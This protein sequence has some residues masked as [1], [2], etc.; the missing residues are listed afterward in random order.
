MK[1]LISLALI[2]AM[3]L[4]F[5]ACDKKENSSDTSTENSQSSQTSKSE[6]SSTSSEPVSTSGSGWTMETLAKTICI[7]GKAI[8]NPLTI[9]SLGKEYSLTYG[10]YN[11]P[12]IS[13]RKKKIVSIRFK[14]ES[15][16]EID[17]VMT[18]WQSEEDSS[19]LSIN[20]IKVGSTRAEAEAAFGKPTSEVELTEN[21]SWS[22]YESG[23]DES[24]RFLYIWIDRET[25]KVSLLAF[26]FV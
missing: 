4:T 1:K 21:I 9:D 11:F 22:Y 26:Y 18:S 8:S 5:T 24:D 15:S 13:Y 7:D 17:M 16:E 10:E 20:G 23:K 3:L 12:F 25:D 2:S 14:D 6:S 19:Y